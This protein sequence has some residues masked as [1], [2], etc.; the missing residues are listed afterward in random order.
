MYQ[1]TTCTH[2]DIDLSD[3]DEAV[4]EWGFC[5]STCEREWNEKQ[6]DRKESGL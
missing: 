4:Q 2:C 1:R 3:Y 6:D 5:S